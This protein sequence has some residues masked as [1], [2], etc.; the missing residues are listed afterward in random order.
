MNLIILET[1]EIDHGLAVL[2]DRRAQHIRKILRA[3]PGDEVRLGILNGPLGSGRLLEIS[4]DQVTLEIML[5]ELPEAAPPTDLILALPRPIMLKRILAQA[6][7]MGVGRIFLINANRVE[8]SFFSASILENENYRIFLRE[9]LE[10][11][12]GTS[13]PLLSV[14]P[15][16]KPFVEDRLPEI[17]TADTIKLAAHPTARSRLHQATPRPLIGRV[18]LAVGPEGGWLDYE[19]DS[20]ISRGFL[21][22]SLGPRILRT[23]TAVPALLAQ[24][25][26]LRQLN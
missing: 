24:I 3:K 5:G 18:V 25:D 11:G 23:D 21:P 6:A 20:F 22:F 8:K 15:R 7:S 12:G 19:I 14:H 13:E 1:H 26:L 16:F 9:G 10:Q 2:K 17:F 4:A